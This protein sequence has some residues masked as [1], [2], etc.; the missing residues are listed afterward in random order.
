LSCLFRRS[1]A[2]IRDS[3]GWKALP[4][5]VAMRVSGLVVAAGLAM[6]APAAWAQ[7]GTPPPGE[8]KSL[9]GSDSELNAWFNNPHLRSFYDLTVATLGKGTGGIDF[10]SYRDQSYAIF[11]KAGTSMGWKADAMVD[12]LKDIPRQVV[13]I[14]K[15]DPKV[16]ASYENF[17]LAL[18]GPP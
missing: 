16:L 4:M 7:H 8:T 12:H 15:D 3:E 18:M 1:G 6:L 5:E 10:E 11:R 14:V 2:E 9:Q 17:M 13:G